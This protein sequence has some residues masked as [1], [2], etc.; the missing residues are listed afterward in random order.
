MTVWE[1]MNAT[2]RARYEREHGTQPPGYRG[3][4]EVRWFAAWHPDNAPCCKCGT[5]TD[6][7]V[8]GFASVKMVDWGGATYRGRVLCAET[9][10]P[11]CWDCER[12]A[13]IVTLRKR[14]CLRLASEVKYLAELEAE[15]RERAA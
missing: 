13:A 1:R 2:E 8:I 6:R 3:T 11:F 15:T 4:G 7:W 12:A 9:Y 14:A 5:M 10:Y